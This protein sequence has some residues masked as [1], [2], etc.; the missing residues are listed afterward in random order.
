MRYI[1]EMSPET[2][3][4]IRALLSQGHYVSVYQFVDRAIE[5]LLHLERQSLQSDRKVSAADS[6]E[7]PGEGDPALAGLLSQCP[8]APPSWPDAHCDDELGEGENGESTWLWGQI[9]SV[10]CVKFVLRVACSLQARAEWQAISLADASVIVGDLATTLG[11]Q[12]AKKDDQ[13]RRKR[14]QRFS[15]SFPKD[16]EKSR[17]RFVSQ[18]LGYVDGSNR[19]QGALAK[20]RFAR[21]VGERGS[22]TI[23]VTEQGYSFASLG[24]PLLASTPDRAAAKPLTVDEAEFYVR[25]VFEYVPCEANA[26]KSI[27]RLIG[28][29]SNTPSGLGAALRSEHPH[30]SDAEVTTYKGG[31]LARMYQL[32]LISKENHVGTPLRY[33]PTE[34]G[35]E[36]LRV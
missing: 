13:D 28:A 29:G 25:H 36:Q 32:G 24:N 16:S 34:F 30:W 27:S 3:K 17:A 23:A 35:E 4:C 7:A 11:R 26:L 12:L 33:V 19:P 22:S 8:D 1:I 21:L 9:N 5:G 15:R 20:L 14:D 31:A 18:Y 6:P 10:F 2:D